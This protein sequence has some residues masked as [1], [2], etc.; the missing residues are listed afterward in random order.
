[1]IEQRVTPPHGRDPFMSQ[2]PLRDPERSSRADDGLTATY[3]GGRPPDPAS[4]DGVPA[5]AGYDEAERIGE[6]G[7]G[8]VYRA[9]DVRLKRLVAVESV[10]AGKRTREK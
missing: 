10:R 4:L 6:G 8:V 7:M 3:L 2:P 9:R 1:M 5:L